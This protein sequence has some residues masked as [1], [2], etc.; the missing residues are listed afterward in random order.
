MWTKSWNQF[1]IFCALPQFVLLHCS[2][3]ASNVSYSLITK[4]YYYVL[5]TKVNYI[6]QVGISGSRW[7]SYHKPQST[8]YITNSVPL[9]IASPQSDYEVPSKAGATTSLNSHFPSFS[10]P[11][12][13]HTGN[14]G[15]PKSA[16]WPT[17]CDQAAA[18]YVQTFFTN[19]HPGL[20]L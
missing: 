8:E 18:A 20:C 2:C 6:G 13:F 4:Y 17:C 14:W 5:S 11:Q 7:H 3:I 9:A 12:L 10:H 16:P 19:S 1:V 15:S